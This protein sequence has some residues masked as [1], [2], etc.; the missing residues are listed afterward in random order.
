MSSAPIPYSCNFA[1]AL[2][3][4]DVGYKSIPV[5]VVYLNLQ[6]SM[7]N[8][9]CVSKIWE[10][11]ESVVLEL[12]QSHHN[13]EPKRQDGWA[14]KGLQSMPTACKGISRSTFLFWPTTRFHITSHSLRLSFEAQTGLARFGWRLLETKGGNFFWKKNKGPKAVVPAS[15]FDC[16]SCIKSKHSI[17]YW[18][19]Y[20]H[21]K[22]KQNSFR[23][24]CHVFV[25]RSS[26][27]DVTAIGRL[28]QNGFPANSAADQT[29]CVNEF[30]CKRIVAL[31]WPVWLRR[32]KWKNPWVNHGGVHTWPW[33]LWCQ[34]SVAQA[35]VFCHDVMLYCT[36][37]I[38]C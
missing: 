33:T 11:F 37:L 15:P 4:S 14:E 16:W 9:V 13:L 5:Y 12:A 30:F 6:Y 24:S 35:D 2:P 17:A 26:L 34:Q 7:R 1:S 25:S 22:L 18:Y 29:L 32:Q 36:M 3:P 38:W 19:F 28:V 20:G 27:F 31:M 23:H 21:N 8:V 10:L